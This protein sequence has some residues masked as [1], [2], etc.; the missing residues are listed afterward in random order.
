M[1]SIESLP[2]I[3]DS[4]WRSFAKS[5]NSDIRAYD[6]DWMLLKRQINGNGCMD[7]QIDM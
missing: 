7:R 5:T 4:T 1:R 2:G 6:L 3:S